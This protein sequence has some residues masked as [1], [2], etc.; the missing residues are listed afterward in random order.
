[1]FIFRFNLSVLR[2]KFC[3][4]TSSLSYIGIPG[5]LSHTGSPFSFLSVKSAISNGAANSNCY[6]ALGVRSRKLSNVDQS[7][8]G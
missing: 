1:M 6:N 4:K 5:R 7:S 2:Q 3:R 8:D